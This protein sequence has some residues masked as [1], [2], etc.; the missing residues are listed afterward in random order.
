MLA[1]RVGFTELHRCKLDNIFHPAALLPMEPWAPFCYRTRK[2]WQKNVGERA[3]WGEGD[4]RLTTHHL[5]G[6]PPVLIRAFFSCIFST[7]LP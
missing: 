2:L 3:V 1:S 7:W 5:T 4:L 6:M